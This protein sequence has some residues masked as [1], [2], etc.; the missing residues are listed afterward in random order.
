MRSTV[1]RIDVVS[2]AKHALGIS[3]VVLQPNLHGHPIALSFHVDRLVVQNLF[4]TIQMLDELRDSAV[5]FELGGLRLAS[6]GV[7]RALI[8][9]RDEQAFIQECEFTQS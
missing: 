9:K 4:A 7:S 1:D 5:V 8:S 6:L 2:E 3:V